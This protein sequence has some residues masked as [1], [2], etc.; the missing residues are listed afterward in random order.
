M[1]AANSSIVG[2]NCA[3]FMYCQCIRIVVPE[4]AINVS[5]LTL[6]VTMGGGMGGGGMGG[7]M[8]GGGMGGGGMGGRGGM[9]G[10]M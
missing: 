2:H 7:G 10:G 1:T 9:G 3:S 4:L 5:Q 6:E 8:G